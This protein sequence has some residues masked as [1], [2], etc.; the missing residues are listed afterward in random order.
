MFIYLYLGSV[1]MIGHVRRSVFSLVYALRLKKEVLR[2]TQ[3]IFRIK[4][5][6]RTKTQLSI[7]HRE[8]LTHHRSI[9]SHVK[10]LDYNRLQICCS[11]AE[12]PYIVFQ[13]LGRGGV[14]GNYSEFEQLERVVKREHQSCQVPLRFCNYLLKVS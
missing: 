4:Y 14:T 11:H 12:T 3:T 2:L 1:A 5:T 8:C 13:I 9:L 10:Y 6:L 7:K